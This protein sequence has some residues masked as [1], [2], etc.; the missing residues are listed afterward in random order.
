MSEPDARRTV[1]WD[2]LTAFLGACRNVRPDTV[3]FH[4]QWIAMALDHAGKRPGVALNEAERKA[5]ATRLACDH[6]EWQVRQARDA[7]ALYQLYLRDGDSRDAK[8]GLTADEQAWREVGATLKT[9][10]RRQNKSYR[11]EQT[12]LGWIRRF[13][14]YISGKS[15]AA[16]TAADVESFLTQ[17]AVEGKVAASTQNQALNALVFLWRYGLERDAGVFDGARAR[18]K[19][20]LPT[21]LSSGEVMEL[22]G[23]LEGTPRLAVSLLYGAGLRVSE[24]VRL[25]IKDVDLDRELLTIRSG[26][27]DRDRTS[28]LPAA[29]RE[30]L[31]AHLAAVRA[32]YDGDRADG[33]AGVH[34]PEALVRKLPSAATE[35]AWFWVFPSRELSVDPRAKVVRRHHVTTDWAQR[36]V[37][38]A[39]KAAGI[40]KRVSAHTLR[41]SFATHLLENGYDIR[42]VQE[43]L[44]HADVRTTMVYTHVAKRHK[45]AARSPLD[46]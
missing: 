39:A 3:G 42:M 33:V 28:M 17:L 19:H 13:Y 29:V 22:L 41:H 5:F 9:R 43:L 37:R 24:L 7:V 4:L 16:V 38:G 8:Q 25:R 6:P 26:K 30:E 15:P 32:L 12:Y 45:L 21:V 40:P 14:L 44:G 36:H 11:T 20:R 2:E 23:Q 27:G 31:V 34:M 10:I 18:T 46:G 35:W 1:V